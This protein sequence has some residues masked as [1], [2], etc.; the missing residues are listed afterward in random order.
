MLSPFRHRKLSKQLRTVRLVDAAAEPISSADYA[1]Y[2]KLPQIAIS[3]AAFNDRA[4]A[5]RRL[6]EKS[7][8]HSFVS[9]VWNGVMDLPPGIMSSIGSVLARFEGYIPTAIELLHVPLRQVTRITVVDDTGFVNVCPPSI[10]WVGQQRISLLDTQVWPDTLGRA[11]E[12]FNVQ[13][14]SGWTIPFK[15]A[16][17]VLTTLQPHGLKNGDVKRV[18]TTSD[19]TLPA[20]LAADTDYYV[21]GA[22]AFTLGLAASL[23]QGLGYAPGDTGTVAG[24]DGTAVYAVL[25]TNS[26]GGVLTVSVSGGTTY[27]TAAAQSTVPGTGSGNGLLKLDITAAAG[28]VV[29]AIV[30]A[31]TA[32]STSSGGTG[33]LFIGS[34][35]NNFLRAIMATMA[36]DF[37]PDKK[38]SNRYDVSESGALPDRAKEL[39]G[40]DKWMNI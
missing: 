13:Y 10:Y 28:A 4:R 9:Q 39:L 3:A 20:G 11:F 17:A 18:W 38:K 21:V 19:G 16:G 30:T 8:G 7:I 1:L 23:P 26:A 5:A 22:T 25:T 40:F 36:V 29:S 34:I 33:S 27:A 15:A 32:I 31:A 12:T 14:T 24:G 6:C 2:E 37:Y 35:E